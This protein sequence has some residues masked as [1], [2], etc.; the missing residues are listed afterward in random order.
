MKTFNIGKGQK[1]DIKV[2][3]PSEAHES[4]FESYLK[5][6]FSY[7]KDKQVV[8]DCLNSNGYNC[9]ILTVY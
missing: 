9:E 4:I 3:L 2:D 7:H 5:L 1:A 8:Q 6:L